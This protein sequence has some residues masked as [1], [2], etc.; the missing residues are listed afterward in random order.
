MRNTNTES[1]PVPP[2]VEKA[3]EVI[4][5]HIRERDGGLPSSHVQELLLE[6][7]DDELEIEEGDIKY[8][9]ERLLERGYFYEVDGALYVTDADR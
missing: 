2:W 9:L 4:A 7:D 8:V 5:P 6:Y 3:Y 1:R